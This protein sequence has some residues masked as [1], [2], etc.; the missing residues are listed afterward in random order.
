M[1]SLNET[2]TEIKSKIAVGNKC[3]YA[4]GPIITLIKI[5]IRLYKTTIRPAVTYVAETY[6]AETHA[7]ETCGA[8]TRA[9]E[10]YGAETWTLTSKIEIMLMIWERKILTKIYGP[11][12]ENGQWRMKTNEELRTKYKSQDIVTIIKIQGLEWLGRVSRMNETRPV[13][14]IF[15]GKLAGRRGR[16]RPRLRW[17]NDVEDDLR[18]LGVKRWRKKALNR[19]E[20]A[21]ILKEIKAKLKGP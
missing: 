13:K 9:A 19:E 7:A 21:S 15:E 16:G 20:W 17:M 2:E 12:K 5:K 18:K 3:Y 10:T 8:E 11:T 1:T 14:K 6:G 4:L